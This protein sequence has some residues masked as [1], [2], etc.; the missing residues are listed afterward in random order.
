VRSQSQAIDQ[1]ALFNAAVELHRSGALAQADARYRTILQSD[2]AHADALFQLAQLCCQQGQLA[3]GIDLARRATALEPNRSR[4]HA[5]MGRALATTGATRE[6]LASF[7]R[8]IACDKSHAGTYADRGGVLVRL[9]RLGEAVES[10]RRAISLEPEV[11]RYWCDLGNAQADLGRHEEA[12]ASFDQ[13]LG[14]DADSVEAHLGRGRA[15][16]LLERADEAR[17][18]L[19]R[20]LMLA[21][22]HVEALVAYGDVHRALSRRDEALASYD[23]A[24]A[25]APN[26]V[27]ALKGQAIALR[28]MDRP[29]E[30]LGSLDRALAMVAPEPSSLT[31]RGCLLHQLGRHDEALEALNHALE[32]EPDHAEALSHRGQVLLDLGQAAEAVH[33]YRRSLA[34]SPTPDCHSK[35]IVALNFDLDVA[36][37][38]QQAERLQWDEQHARLLSADVAP[39][40]NTPDPYRRLRIG[41]VGNR[42]DRQS[43]TVAFASAIVHRDADRFEVVCYASGE[44]NDDVG[45][46]LR[47]S[48]DLWR[49]VGSWSD[50]DLAQGIRADSIDILVDVTG[51]CGEHRLLAFARKPAPVQVT[52]WGDPM[53]TGLAAMDYVF[54]DP[55]LVPA[56]LRSFLVEKPYDLPCCLGY[57]RP[58]QWPAP[59]PLPAMSR[60]Y[61]TFGSLNPIAAIQ[62]PV[63]RSWAAILRALPTTRLIIESEL[64]FDDGG[65]RLDIERVFEDEG[66][67]AD[68]VEFRGADE[69]AEPL[70]AYQEIDIALDPFPYSGGMSALDA[71]S[72]GV[73]VVTWAGRTVSSRLAASSLAGLG[74]TDLI[75]ARRSDY[76]DVAIGMARDVMALAY[77]RA[78]L[79]GLFINSAIGDSVRYARSVEAAYRATWE[80]WC[81]NAGR[82]AKP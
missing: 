55:V 38:D 43:A 24:L 36:A 7:D 29:Q 9:G 71:L 17:L 80:K 67:E 66:V 73:P 32:I 46:R 50:D 14:L 64:T 56:S 22:Q 1:T 47:T 52:G 21:P 37:A 77:L 18:S 75:A 26:D 59:S 78:S 15:F 8:A 53:G 62:D 34:V 74:L 28:A 13:A 4:S 27:P 58:D 48:A 45:H 16:L 6:A 33:S 82:Q 70:T 60:G 54:V 10:Y 57:W 35:L 63:V 68:R 65:R 72:M 39:H 5:L 11:P 76:V 25:L 69:R 20:A 23:R 41:Y 61:V 44:P 79:R 42:F 40:R 3:E 81:A 2:P 12:L 30:A 51:H 49:Q 19:E 31:L